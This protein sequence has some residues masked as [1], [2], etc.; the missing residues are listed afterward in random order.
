MAT[1]S[2]RAK[3]GRAAGLPRVQGA[4]DFNLLPL[5]ERLDEGARVRSASFLDAATSP[6]GQ[7]CLLLVLEDP[8]A[9]DD[10]PEVLPVGL[11]ERVREVLAAAL[12]GVEVR[13]F[14]GRREAPEPAAV[15]GRQLA[16]EVRELIEQAS[17]ETPEER[18][19]ILMDWL[20]ERID[21]SR[22]ALLPVEGGVAGAPLVFHQRG[23]PHGSSDPRL[24]PRHVVS[25]V[26][27]TRQAIVAHDVDDP[28]NVLAPGESVV[29]QRVRSYMAVPV[30]FRGQL[31]AVAYVDLLDRRRRFSAAEQATFE[32]FAYELARP[33]LDILQQR[34]RE[35][36]ER[37]RDYY[38]A[39][40][41]AE[42]NV[43]VSPALDPVL[44]QARKVAPHHDV[45][46]LILG[47]TGV[48]KEWLAKLVH[49]ESGRSGPFVAVN[50][51]AIEP[52]L[53]EATLMGS[54]RGAFTGAVDRIGRVE[55]AEGGT[56]F[57]DEL[58]DLDPA[59]QVKL[60]RFLQDRTLRR[61]GGTQERPVDV[62]VL[63][64]TNKP[65]AELRGQGGL[66]EDL[67]QRF[68]PPLEV[69]PL[70]RRREEILPLAAN[71]IAARCQELGRIPPELGDDLRALLGA[72]PW[73][74]NVRQL[75][76]ALKHALV[77]AGDGPLTVELLSG[78]LDD[79]GTG[80]PSS[81]PETWEEYLEDRTTREREWARA[82]L[83]AADGRPEIAA[84]QVGCPSTTFRDILKKH[85]LRKK[86]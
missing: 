26:A 62:R 29:A 3:E 2:S 49:R 75:E 44:D 40:P 48:G 82:A 47:E 58:G 60:L 35:E 85:G 43:P 20:V 83:E 59:N 66:R 50:V 63:A 72:H 55:E 25:H 68:G 19:A 38:A 71:W 33:L 42:A 51:S 6:L 4:T 69:P 34:E 17:G 10:E 76:L 39:N 11:G 23:R 86:R 73:P 45:S 53:F 28:T 9:G 54:V 61:V 18:A 31:I 78:L 32:V 37:L 30:V 56:L 80:S 65:R 67:L 21:A 24:V 13:G 27:R 79:G 16:A 52:E 5:I 84:R 36:Y 57:L 7:P 74:G 41:K 70:R 22:C 77:L 14:G 81:L 8:E 1:R 15:D 12:A 46:L 64:A